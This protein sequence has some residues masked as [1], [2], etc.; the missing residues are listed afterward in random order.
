[1]DDVNDDGNGVK[2]QRI[3]Q[4]KGSRDGDSRF[5]IRGLPRVFEEGLARGIFFAC[6]RSETWTASVPQ[7]GKPMGTW[8]EVETHLPKV[9]NRRRNT[10]R[11]TSFFG[12][13][14]GQLKCV[15]VNLDYG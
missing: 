2:S 15:T 6:W 10:A 8:A 14:R 12:L 13:T 3:G 9:Q 1:M 4:G 11:E 7:G 5:R